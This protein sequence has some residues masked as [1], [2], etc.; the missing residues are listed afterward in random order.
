MSFD[1]F[2]RWLA[3]DAAPG[4]YNDWRLVSGAGWSDLALA[5][6]LGL[7]VLALVASLLGLRRVPWRRRWPLVVLRVGV[8][9]TVGVL[10]LEPAV[11][12]RAISRIRS[13]VAVLIDDSS[14]M[15]LATP[16]GTR[17]ERVVAHLEGN[18]AEFEELERRAVVEWH[19]FDGR[20]RPIEGV[21][22]TLPAEGRR[23]DLARALSEIAWQSSGREL[24][25]L[26]IYSDGADT[27]GLNEAMARREAARLGAPIYTVGFDEDAAAPDLAIRRIP[28]DDFAF[29]HN[30]VTFDVDLEVKGLGIDTVDVTLE[31][32]GR[33]LQT[34]LAKFEGG[35]ATTSFEFK[36]RDIGKQVY[37][38]AVPVQAGE[39]VDSNNEKSVVLKVIRDR[40]RVLQVAGRPSWDQRFLR[41]MLKRNPSVDLISFFIL[42]STTDLQKASQDELALI[43]FPVH[44]LFTEELDTFD[45]VIYQ[46]FSYRPYRMDRYLPNIR[47]YVRGGG[48]FLMV[49]GDQAFEDG[50]Y[51]GTAVADVL[52][53]RLGGAARWDSASYRPRLTEE[54]RVHP[55]TRIGEAGEPPD[56]VFRRLPELEGV[57]P[58]LGLMPGAAALLTHPSI[59]GNPP[60]VATRE[61][62]EGRS[63]AV[64]TDSLWFWRFLAVGDGGA[65]R[66][67]DR[68]WS[69]S[70]RWLIRDPDLDRVRVRVDRSV[71]MRGDPVGAEVEVLGPDYRPLG[72]V[73][74]LVEMVRAASQGA[75]AD[76]PEAQVLETGPD[77]VVMVRWED[78]APGTYVVRAEAR[79]GDV[80]VGEAREPLI[81]EASDV[82]RQAPF[83]RP[84]LLRALS[85][86]SG[87][88]FA[89]IDE[90]LPDID[91]EDARRVEVDRSRKVSIWDRWPMFL[92]LLVLAAAEWWG[93]RRVGLL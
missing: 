38:V 8:A 14:S 57:N 37:R 76:V 86:G 23:T 9:L 72:G 79:D 71:A 92:L 77:G 66:E 54:G 30:T 19:L 2:V 1:S 50:W 55:I 47:N 89:S 39:T 75:E 49:G 63:L 11:E 4:A 68:F 85:E 43:P 51:A 48:G 34:K 16:R 73:E 27:E 20:S 60:V 15:T 61:V 65:G 84:N 88:R 6:G 17:A 26:V 58:S 25:A 36:P 62:G 10:L 21:P 52:P 18:L 83:P 29:V 91:F 33:I 24:G 69:T 35:R 28:A 13:R 87:G 31:H 45:V 74:V 53:V 42:R 12:L 93:R 46:N 41:E 64:T 59:P 7:L 56:A 22:A 44:E 78:V 80:R 67:F 82:E 40:L 81:V 70:L 3:P 90:G 32:D 5:V